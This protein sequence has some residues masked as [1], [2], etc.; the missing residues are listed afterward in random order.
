MKICIPTADKAGMNG[1]IHGHFGSAPFFTI[2]DTDTGFVEIVDNANQHHAHGTC[3]PLGSMEGKG[4][5]TVIATAMG[6]RVVQGL[7]MAKIR[8]YKTSATTVQEAI[9]TFNNGILEAFTTS[10]AC[11]ADHCEKH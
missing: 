2:V 11:V 1:H 4:V 6:A 8:A 10:T 9:D 3:H 5:N 7:N